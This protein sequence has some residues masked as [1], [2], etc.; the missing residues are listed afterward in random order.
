[1]RSAIGSIERTNTQN[2]RPLYLG[3][4]A[5]AHASLGEPEIGLELL[6]EAIQATETTNER[7]FEA[8]LHRLR[9]EILL[10]VGKPD[11]AESGLR[12]AVKIAQQQSAHWWELRA[13][14][15]LARH[16]RQS[17]SPLEA[18]SLLQPVYSWYAEGF[19]T[20]TL[21]E[22]KTL[23]DELQNLSSTQARLTVV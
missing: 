5:V 8:E 7:F 1:M 13:A 10:Q 20:N 18:Y 14:T 23:L 17:G 3:H 19:D 12:R 21:K 4:F 2:R 16:L 11:Q 22:A 9:G 15:S 6:D